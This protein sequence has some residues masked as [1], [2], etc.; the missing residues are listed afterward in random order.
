MG[1]GLLA[2]ELIGQGVNNVTGDYSRGVTGFWVENGELAYPVE[3]LTIAGNL[4][5]MY[6]GLVEIGADTDRRGNVHTGSWLLEKLTIAG[7]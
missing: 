3:E 2:T 5:D 7:G 1:T 6:A 4:R